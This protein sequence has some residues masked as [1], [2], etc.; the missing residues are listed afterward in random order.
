MNA[1]GRSSSGRRSVGVLCRGVWSATADRHGSV[2]QVA[3]EGDRQ[4]FLWNES[5]FTWQRRL[6][7]IGPIDADRLRE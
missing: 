2:R 5:R 1:G 6:D 7:V 3:L 4:V